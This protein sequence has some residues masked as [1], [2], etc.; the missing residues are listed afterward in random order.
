MFVFGNNI[1]SEEQ[2]QF[3]MAFTN[4]LLITIIKWA[5]YCVCKV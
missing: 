2:I 3:L 1:Y 4:Q 5:R